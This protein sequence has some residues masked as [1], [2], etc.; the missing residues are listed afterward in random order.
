MEGLW[1]P[2]GL[3][4]RCSDWE[5][6]GKIMRF[7]QSP[8]AL[9]FDS[10]VRVYFSTRVPHASGS[11]WKSIPAYCDYSLNLDSILSPPKAIDYSPSELG[12][13]DEDGIFPFSPFRIDGK[14]FALTTGWSRRVSVDVETGVGLMESTDGG[15]SFQRVGTGPV[16]SASIDE[17]FLVCD[18]FVLVTPDQQSIF[19]SYGISWLPDPHNGVW[20]RTYKIS[21]VKIGDIL[22][23]PLGSGRQILP[24]S[25]GK[26]ESQALPTV[27]QHE[28]RFHMAFC[29]RG[30]FDFRDKREEMYDLGYASSE[31]G[32]SWTRDD[33]TFSFERTTFDS[34][35]RCYPNIFTIGNK[36]YLLYNGNNFGIE[37]FGL[38]EWTPYD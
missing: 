6:D 2:R 34:E 24:D 18:G 38:A 10:H 3:I 33:R 31:D 17:P 30:T 11:G 16:L 7:A 28:N 23:P 8:Q 13:F 1:V 9:V 25:R 14:I 35:M 37:G 32:E 12:A 29:H 5:L 4:F 15:T 27:T 26:L 36:L 20:E 19:Y 22:R 21:Q